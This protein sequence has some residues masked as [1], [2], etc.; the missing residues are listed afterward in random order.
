MSENSF[1]NKAGY[2][3][4]T[5]AAERLVD[6]S[7]QIKAKA[8]ALGVKGTFL[9]SHEGLNAF[10]AAPREQADA[11]S[12]FI[13]S[14]AEFSALTFK[15]SQSEECPFNQLVVRIKDEIISMGHQEVQPQ[16]HT[17]PYIEPEVLKDWYENGENFIILDTRNDYEVALGTFDN[18]VELNIESFREFPDAVMMLPE[19]MKQKPVVTFCTGGIRCEKAAEFMSQKGFENVYQLQ[20]GIL[21]YFEKMGGAYYHGECFIF[22]KR[23]S[24]NTQ[25]QPTQTERCFAHQDISGE[26]DLNQ[27]VACPHCQHLQQARAAEAHAE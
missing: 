3:F 11:L 1:I 26:S 14:L 18:A 13:Q 7:A 5:L 19:E 12:C 21:N 15:E 10:F 23:L 22:D 27:S 24:V 4:V 16:H 17:A 6:L 2:Q 8:F 25:L 20:G 9:L